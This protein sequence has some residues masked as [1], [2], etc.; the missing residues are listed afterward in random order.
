MLCRLNTTTCFKV[1]RSLKPL[2]RSAWAKTE[3]DRLNK[4][5]LKRILDALNMGNIFRQKYK[6]MCETNSFVPHSKT[7]SKL[8][9]KMYDKNLPQSNGSSRKCEI[10][11]DG[12]SMKAA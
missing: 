8:I 10:P 2:G 5:K 6:K 4:R 11:N 12:Y 1:Y 3:S 7:N 9:L